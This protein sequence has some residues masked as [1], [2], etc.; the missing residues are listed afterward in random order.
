VVPRRKPSEVSEQE[1]LEALRANSWDL[2]PAADQLGIPRTSIYDLI[3]RSKNIRTAGDVS[4]EELTR[5]FHECQGDLDAMVRRL[6]VSKQ[7]LR[8]RIKELGLEP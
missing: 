6:E 3:E 5:C 4:V 1:L 2:K 8:R 7:A